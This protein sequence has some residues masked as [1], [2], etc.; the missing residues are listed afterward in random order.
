MNSNVCA[1]CLPDKSHHI[2]CRALYMYVHVRTRTCK[3]RVHVCRPIAV[4]SKVQVTSTVHNT[5]TCNVIGNFPDWFP[6]CIM[7][8]THVHMIHVHVYCTLYIINIMLGSWSYGSMLG[9]TRWF[10]L[11][12]NTAHVQCTHVHTMSCSCTCCLL[13]QNQQFLQD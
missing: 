10:A 8:Y 4:R 13:Y 9:Y 12:H 3:C 1:Q 7:L 5:S 2:H 6:Y 11:V